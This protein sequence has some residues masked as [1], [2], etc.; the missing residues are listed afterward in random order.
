[1]NWIDI[2]DHLLQSVNKYGG[3]ASPFCEKLS[4]ILSSWEIQVSWAWKRSIPLS[5]CP[6]VLFKVVLIWSLYSEETRT[7]ACL[8]ISARE[9]KDA[10][11]CYRWI[12]ER[13]VTITVLKIPTQCLEI[14]QCPPWPARLL[15]TLSI[16]WFSVFN[17]NTIVQYQIY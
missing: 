16:I 13:K 1:M 4:S 5:L 10:I 14:K 17:F 15:R 8:L 11:F 7:F 9:Y 6:A 3:F 2:V 12:G